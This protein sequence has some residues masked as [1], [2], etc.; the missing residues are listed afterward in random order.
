[1]ILP[2]KNW[3]GAV[4]G[5]GVVVGAAAVAAIFYLL[6]YIPVFVYVC[7]SIV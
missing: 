3:L 4:A 5:A 2:N 7:D 1:M 6:L